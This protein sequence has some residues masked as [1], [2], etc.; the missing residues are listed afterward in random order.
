MCYTLCALTLLPSPLVTKNKIMQQPP[1]RT[2]CVVGCLPVLQVPGA[3][4]HNVAA[5]QRYLLPPTLDYRRIG[6]VEVGSHCLRLGEGQSSERGGFAS[7][8]FGGGGA[9][10]VC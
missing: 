1:D 6:I 5:E 10:S 7:D 9:V 3:D 8:L 4:E 2:P